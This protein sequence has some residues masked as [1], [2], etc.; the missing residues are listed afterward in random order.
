MAVLI[1]NADNRLVG[2]VLGMYNADTITGVS[3]TSAGV[4]GLAGTSDTTDNWNGNVESEGQ[5][6]TAAVLGAMPVIS[7]GIAPAWSS[8]GFLAGGPGVGASGESMANDGV[9]G[10]SHDQKHSGVLKR[11]RHRGERQRNR[12]ARA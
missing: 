5:P 4:V 1:G 12:D 2:G 3:G 7:Q 9:Q 10:K 11:Q 8:I 6:V